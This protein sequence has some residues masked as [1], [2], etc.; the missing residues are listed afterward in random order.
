[1]KLILIRHAESE[2]N[3]IVERN[4]VEDLTIFDDPVLTLKGKIQALALS[5]E[6]YKLNGYK[7]VE[8]TVICSPLKRATQTFDCLTAH[9]FKNSR[10]VYNPLVVERDYGGISVAEFEQGKLDPI[11]FQP[12][13]GE[14][15]ADV[16]VRVNKFLKELDSYYENTVVIISH[17]EFLLCLTAA[18][19]GYDDVWLADMLVNAHDKYFN[20]KNA[21]INVVVYDKK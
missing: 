13:N 9:N 14:T 8:R 7:S 18:V 3:S 2:A 5:L 10:V 21:E 15:I 20:F 19:C 4:A 6:L 16:K 11:N 17:R 12:S 1:M